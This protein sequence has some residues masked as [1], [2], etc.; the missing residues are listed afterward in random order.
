[1][2]CTLLVADLKARKCKKEQLHIYN[3]D[4]RHPDRNYMEYVKDLHDL[5][6]EG[7][8][9]RAERFK[10]RTQVVSLSGGLDSRTVLVGLLKKKVPL[11]AIT[12]RDYYNMLRRD[13]PVVKTL[14]KTYNLESK[15][16]NL[17]EDNIPYFERMVYVKDGQST[18]GSMGAV[19]NSMEIIEREYGKDIVYYVGDEGNYTTAPRYGG[20]K[21]DSASGTCA[22]DTNEKQH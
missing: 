20:P 21:I 6:L 15:A 14:D 16:Y 1:M 4:D 8:G 22:P 2:P 19:L 7:I 3:F 11:K 13:Y 18:M 10:D 5:F 17:I 9:N 12:F